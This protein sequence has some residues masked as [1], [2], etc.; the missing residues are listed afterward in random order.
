MGWVARERNLV[1]CADNG[2]IEVRDHI[3]VQDSPTV[4]FA[5][6]RKVCI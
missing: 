1:F 2:R 6:L 4:K 5:M 3:W